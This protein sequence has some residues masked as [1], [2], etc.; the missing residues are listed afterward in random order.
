MV[1]LE[2]VSVFSGWNYGIL[3]GS[4]V[5]CI[6]VW[7]SVLRDCFCVYDFYLCQGFDLWGSGGRMAIYDVHYFPDRRRAATL[8]WNYG[9]IYE[10]D[11]Y[12]SKGQAEIP[13]ERG[14]LT[15]V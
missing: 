11:V 6:G 9:T 1:L 10:Q 15:V 12:G 7:Y 13:C 14:V 4:A 5:N 3:D 2:T 8:Y